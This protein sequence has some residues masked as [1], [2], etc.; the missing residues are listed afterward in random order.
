MITYSA[1][2]YYIDVV[3]GCTPQIKGQGEF[4]PDLHDARSA[5][6]RSRLR[7]AWSAIL[8]APLFVARQAARLVPSSMN[9][10]Y[11]AH[12]EA[13][14]LAGSIRR[15]EG[16][17]PHLLTDIGIEQ[18]AAGV[19]VMIGTNEPAAEALRDERA[20]IGINT[21]PARRSIKAAPQLAWRASTKRPAAELIGAVMS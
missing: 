1:A 13:R 15:L 6:R 17:A 16:T 21:A 9:A 19:Y 7:S 3:C 8:S 4:F 2:G 20:A 14:V 11:T 18:V 5:E 12:M 10:A